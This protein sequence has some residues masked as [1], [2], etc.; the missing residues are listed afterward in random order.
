MLNTVLVQRTRFRSRTLLL[1]GVAVLATLS[2][3]APRETTPGTVAA[4]TNVGR[5]SFY[6]AQVG[7]SWSYLPEGESI[8]STPYLL[9]SQGTTL[10]GDRPALGF[11]FTGRGADQTSYRTVS[12]EGQYLLGF[13]KPGLIVTLDPPLREFPATN[14]WREGLTWSGRS[15]VRVIS[16]GRIMQEGNVQYRY[17]VL[18]KRNV[19]IGNERLDVWVVNR[20]ITGDVSSLF[21]E[22]S[23]N[24]WFAPYIGEVRTPEGL[25]QINRNYRGS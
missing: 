12:D 23:Q 25:L 5:V 19:T 7:L 20:Q 11:R 18:E 15:N 13:T 4:S 2:G 9:T 3:C 24:L 14:A 8:T 10:F 22:T 21:P 6:P 17:T 16:N 1:L